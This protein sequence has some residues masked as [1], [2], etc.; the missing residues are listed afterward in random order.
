MKIFINVKENYFPLLVFSV[1]RQFFFLNM[2]T[3]LKQNTIR[4]EHIEK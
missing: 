1:D 2:A 3:K 4:P